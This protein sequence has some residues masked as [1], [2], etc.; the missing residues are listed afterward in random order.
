MQH[1]HRHRE[2]D[3]PGR[4]R[5][6]RQ[7]GA[8]RT[9]DREALGRPDHA[10]DLREEE[11]LDLKH[12][13]WFVDDER[14]DLGQGRRRDH[15]ERLLVSVD[16]DL[17]FRV[18]AEHIVRRVEVDQGHAV[19]LGVAWELAVHLDARHVRSAAGVVHQGAR[20]GLDD[21]T[22]RPVALHVD[23]AGARRRVFRVQ[24]ED[25]VVRQEGLDEVEGA[26]RLAVDLVEAEG[27]VDRHR[28]DEG[29]VGRAEASRRVL[30]RLHERGHADLRLRPIAARLRRQKILRVVEGGEDDDLLHAR[31]ARLVEARHQRL[32]REVE[33]RGRLAMREAHEGVRRAVRER[34]HRDRLRVRLP[35]GCIGR[36]REGRRSVRVVLVHRRAAD[37]S[38]PNLGY[39]YVRSARCNRCLRRDRRRLRRDWHAHCRRRRSAAVEAGEK[40]LDLLRRHRAEHRRSILE[41]AER[42]LNSAR[43]GHTR[44][45]RRRRCRL[46]ELFLSP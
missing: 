29:A 9:L 28:L 30:H 7:R 23:C 45:R 10:R 16:F 31:G 22:D 24:V 41:R 35:G 12:G 46:S 18:R 34:S 14:A 40:R 20:E 21:E 4:L 13:G 6:A 38:A 32:G 27:G 25:V 19:A 42:G 43:C 37:R 5:E 2:R 36:G 3:L 17:D 39:W 11:F 15:V 44:R 26:A 8:R 33:E 1:P